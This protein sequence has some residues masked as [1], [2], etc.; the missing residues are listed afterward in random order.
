MKLVFKNIWKPEKGVV[1]RDL[2][3]NFFVFQFFSTA[4]KMFLLNEGPWSFDGK[5]LL[6]KEVS[7]LEKPSEVTFTTARFWVKAY[8]L[9]AKKQTL[10]CAQLIGSKMGTFVDC[11]ELSLIGVDK[12]LTFCV[13]IDI[14]TPLLRGIRVAVAKQPM[15][16][17]LG[18]VKLQDFCYGC[19]M[20]DHLYAGCPL[21]NPQVSEATLQYGDWLR[22]SPLKSRSRAA[23]SEMK[24]D[25]QL[26]QTFCQSKAGTKVRA[27][28]DFSGSC[29][30]PMLRKPL[31]ID[32]N[33]DVSSSMLVDEG[34][35]LNPPLDFCKRKVDDISVAGRNIGKVRVMENPSFG[36]EIQPNGRNESSLLQLSEVG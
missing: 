16:I 10:A 35:L 25:K 6:F 9:P 20:L 7:G 26:Y 34:S 18:Y 33:L 28:L 5:I 11:D 12:C 8:D 19:G 31:P 24:E 15:W 1:I 22:S 21:Y 13:D 4:D 14:R 3:S 17:R 2:K 30:V 32:P 23:S 29:S 36:E 27:Q